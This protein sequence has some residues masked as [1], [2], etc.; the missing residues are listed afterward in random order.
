MVLMAK[1]PLRRV[2]YRLQLELADFIIVPPPPSTLRFRPLSQQCAQAANYL[3]N[4]PAH[5]RLIS[6]FL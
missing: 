4:L 5:R 3:T 6:N 2:F 1:N